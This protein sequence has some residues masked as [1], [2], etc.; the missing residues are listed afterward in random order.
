[1]AAVGLRQQQQ[2]DSSISSSGGGSN[3]RNPPYLPTPTERLSLLAYPVILVFGTL[4]SVLSPETRAAPYDTSR[5]SHA[6][7]H[8]A[9][10]YFARKDNLLNVLFVKRGWAWVTAAFVAFALFGHPALLA[11]ARRRIHA[12]T[13]W[14][15]VTACWAL[16]TQ[17]C[18]GPP[19]ID[20][21]FRITGGRCR[22]AHE[23]VA[24]EGVGAAAT[25]DVFTAAAC[26]A[27]GGRWSGGHDISGHVFL[28]VLGSY[29]LAQE[30]GW[31]LVRAGVLARSAG[32]REERCVVMLDGAVK[33]AG[34][35][36]E[37]DGEGGGGSGA[38]D[39]AL[40]L[41]GRF[42][43]AVI[44]LCLWMLLMTAI[45]FHTW[46]EKFT[47]LLVALMAIYAVYFV[48]RFVP[49][50][51]SVIDQFA[52]FARKSADHARKLAMYLIYGNAR[53]LIATSHREAQDPAGIGR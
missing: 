40:G 29:F 9:P 31:V 6:Q 39:P 49:A 12:V 43:V 30:V 38:Y 44:V 16:V 22:A 17:W 28:L 45:Y 21:G 32:V 46:F 37:R 5:Q 3:A 51:R 42:A 23:A 2:N 36:A 4:F 50:V 11:S 15:L 53:L 14:A 10:S 27:A 26:R 8:T 19:L 34:V 13:R 20:R 25:K 33:G 35:E 47:G 41:A 24:E 48:P 1:M 18:F 52:L 7:D